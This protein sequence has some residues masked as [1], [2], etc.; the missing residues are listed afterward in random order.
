M[1]G[2]RIWPM[3][4]KSLIRHMPVIALPPH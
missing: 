3:V 4:G 2:S 1:E